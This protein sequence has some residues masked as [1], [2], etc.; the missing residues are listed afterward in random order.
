MNPPTEVFRSIQPPLRVLDATDGPRSLP[1]DLESETLLLSALMLEESG[2]KTMA[3][4]QKFAL[5]GA[6]FYDSRHGVVF[7][8]LAGLYERQAPLDAS[9]L[10][11]E[12]K[13]RKEIDRA[14]GLAYFTTL[15]GRVPTEASASFHLEIV[16]DL[17]AQRQALREFEK[18]IEEIH[19][20]T[21]GGSALVELLELKTSW[22]ARAIDYLRAGQGTMAEAAAAAF[23]RTQ[24]KLDGKED[25][26]RWLF[27]GL[28]E[29]DGRFGALDANNEDWLVV[30]GAL[31][32][33]GKSSFA[34]QIAITNL[35]AGKTVQL[36]LI[37]TSLGLWLE[38]AACVLAGVNSKHLSTLT[39][40]LRANYEAALA[41]MHG[42]LGKTLWICEEHLPVELIT[43]RI[44]DQARR[45]GPCDLYVVDHMHLLKA[46]KK[47]GQ[48]EPEMGFI[49]K[50][51]ARCGKRH[52]R[53]MLVLAQ[54]NRASKSDGGNRR[55]ESHNIRDSGEIEQAA[56][57]IILIHTPTDDMT[58]KEQDMERPQVMVEVI[59]S[60]HNNGRTGKREFWFRRDLTTFVDIGEAELSRGRANAPAPA[61]DGRPKA[62]SRPTSK[63]DY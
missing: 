15:S 8:A 17:C 58:G 44:D 10:Y 7:D 32:M 31:S 38:N 60:K 14:G 22:I 28:R 40:D 41:E 18:G 34:R 24:A 6:A 52:N 43:A 33:N 63:A 11:A 55:P 57:R 51:F 23:R 49:A 35:R 13:A 21:G 42:Y 45:V 47:F 50:E 56:R 30:L 61:P 29:F 39:K 3:Q 2:R 48:R 26:S 59:Q 12:L 9:A 36:F 1:H 25:K 5:N 4:C 46:Q 27:T 20:S 19:A 54:L 53:T 37:E 16:R 62:T